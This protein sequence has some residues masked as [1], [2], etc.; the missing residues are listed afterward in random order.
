MAY[1]IWCQ[2]VGPG[3]AA[4]APLFIDANLTFPQFMGTFDLAPSWRA[5]YASFV[6]GAFDGQGELII[7]PKTRMVQDYL[8]S[9]EIVPRFSYVTGISVS[10]QTVGINIK[11]GGGGNDNRTFPMGFNAYKIW[12]RGNQSYGVTFSN[13]ADFF[14]ISDS[15]V[16]G[17]CVWAYRGAVGD[18]FV[19]PGADANALVFGNW[20]QGDVTV[21]YDYP[22]RS[23]II[24][25]NHSNFNGSNRGGVVNDMRIAVFTNGVGVPVHNGGF[26]IYSPNGQQCVFS[27]YRTP[28]TINQF[29]SSS[30][31]NTGLGMPMLC[32]GRSQGVMTNNAGG[33]M[34]N[35]ER[36]ST[37]VGSSIGTGW[38]PIVTSWTNQYPI[39][40]NIATGTAVPI[41]DGSLI[42]A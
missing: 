28:F 29:I 23:M 5:T 38:G 22:S 4:P 36:S 25:R 10:G 6:V 2:P 21:A 27:T 39:D 16:V 26:N 8:P 7:V 34:W 42:F 20:N 37:M 18:G 33:W 31:G 19:V 41:I 24:C 12:P 15:G 11:P 30:G 9:P 3:P 17:Q 13:S 35:H 32:L 14:S 1:G 40:I